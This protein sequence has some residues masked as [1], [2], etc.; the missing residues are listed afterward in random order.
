MPRRL[1]VRV[2]TTTV[3]ANMVGVG[4]F[5]T[6]GFQAAHLA[7]PL[8]MILTWVG[9]G[10]IALCGA[11]VYAELA[12]MMPNAGGDYVYLRTAFHPA[13]G[14]ASGWIS[15]TAGF[16]AP[17]AA[18]SLAFGQY[19]VRVFPSSDVDARWIAVALITAAAVLHGYDTVVGGRVQAA[20]TIGKV[21]II[22]GFIA[23]GLLFGKGSWSHFVT[24]RGELEG[25]P[26]LD[27]ATSLMYVSFAYSG[28]NAATYVAGEIS[29][30]KKTLPWALL[31]GTAI[32]MLLY[33][34]LNVVFIYA[35][36]PSELAGVLEVGDLAA[37]RLFGEA[38]GRALS[39]AIAIA[40]VSSVS[41]MV[42]AGPR[43][44]AAMAED[45]ALPQFLSRRSA[46]GVPV[47]A[48]VTQAVLAS[49]LVGLW[50]PDELIRHVGFGLA[51][52]SALT[53]ASVFVMRRRVGAA[54]GA[55][56]TPGYPATPML[57]I[58]LSGGIATA[59]LTSAV[60][61]RPRELVLTVGTFVV[62]AFVFALWRRAPVKSGPG[63]C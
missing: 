43:V 27:F 20:F 13:L 8:T 28:W 25:L 22:V 16:S 36:P 61:S 45:R 17:I 53:V 3:V 11:A 54:D 48:I 55:Y 35:A 1:G 15:L 7:D 9:G 62:G 32:V 30:P 34:L 63:R 26:V 52:F 18:A 39:M 14:F 41:S 38:T 6:A 33:V 2:A 50:N 51:L 47:N 56:R 29:N 57:F 10:V 31:G 24:R 60:S 12:T 23:A 4:V 59:Q 58:L 5:T 49:C 37:R 42:M 46:R 40:L 21:A 44:Y 19:L